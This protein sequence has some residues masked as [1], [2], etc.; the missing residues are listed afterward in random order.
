[1]NNEQ[2]NTSGTQTNN[3]SSQTANQKPDEKLMADKAA[4][5]IAGD[6]KFLAAFLK[7]L[8]SPLTLIA[9][10]A[11][12]IYWID[13]KNKP[14]YERLKVEYEN[15]KDDFVEMKKKYKKLK[16]LLEP[17]QQ[18]G[19]PESTSKTIGQPSA[20]YPYKSTYLD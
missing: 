1:M 8:L 3:A 20:A 19:L 13:K 4:E 11:L 18:H 7:I 2:A 5:T 15:L 14:E 10:A 12:V 9:G 16:G 6:N 17:K